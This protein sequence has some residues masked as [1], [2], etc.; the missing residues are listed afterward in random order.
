MGLDIVLE[1]ERSNKLASVSDHRGVVA[2]VSEIQIPQPAYGDSV[3][4]SKM[5]FAL[6]RS[7]LQSEGEHRELC[8]LRFID[9]Y[10]TTMF[11]QLQ[12]PMLIRELDWLRSTVS[13]EDF[14]VIWAIQTLAM[15]CQREDLLFLFF[16]GD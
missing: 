6:P 2:S 15:R 7:T 1:D 10:G 13:L 4:Y 5:N 9:P 16:Y 11:N 12:M 14:S 3:W 8:C